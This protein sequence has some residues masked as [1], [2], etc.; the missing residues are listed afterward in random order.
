M[1]RDVVRG[2]ALCGVN[3]AAGWFRRRGDHG[4]GLRRSRGDAAGAGAGHL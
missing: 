2:L 4:E 1:G 3:S